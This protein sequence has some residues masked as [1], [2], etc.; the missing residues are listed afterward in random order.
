[1]KIIE[2]SQLI[3]KAKD[4]V[5]A[6]IL[7]RYDITSNELDILTF[8]KENTNDTATNIVNELLFTK[9]HLSLSIENLTKKGYITKYIDEKNKKVIH[10]ELTNKSLPILK[11]GNAKRREFIDLMLYN[12]REKDKKIMEKVFKQMN[13]N[14][15]NILGI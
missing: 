11:E 13:K 12:I 9:S 6:D 1:M 10:L 4:K 15:N 2:Q 8:L 3:R 14:I 7:K 5:F